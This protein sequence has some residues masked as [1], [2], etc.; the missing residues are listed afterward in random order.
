M[1]ATAGGGVAGILDGLHSLDNLEG[2]LLEEA[3][4]RSNGNLSAAARLLGI[5]R[6]KLAYRLKKRGVS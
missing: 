5:T 2:R 4:E 3:A 6:P 1:P